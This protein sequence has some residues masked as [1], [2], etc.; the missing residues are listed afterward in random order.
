VGGLCLRQ[1]NKQTKT[2]MARQ[3]LIILPKLCNCNED[4]DKQW[5]V[6]YSCRD[7]RTGK[8][9][10]FRHYDGFTGT[11][12]HT[13][14][15]HAKELIEIF[16]ARLRSGW[17]PFTDDT[18]A[19][20]ND[21]ID[22]KTVAELYGSRQSGNNTVRLW[23]SRYLDSIIQGVRHSTYLTYKS[24]F[25]IFIL[26]LERE[27]VV[28][29]D[30]ATIDNKLIVMFFQYLLDERKLSH[31]SIGNY[32][33]L[34]IN[35]FSYFKKQKLIP[36]NPVFELP[37]CNR[38]NDQAP[39]PIQREDIEVFKKEIRKDPE[40]WLAVQFE[41][42]CGM[43]PGH[44]IRELKIKDIDYLAGTIYINRENAKAVETRIVTIPK[45]FLDVIRNTYQLQTF[46]RE[47]YIFGKGG[48]PG[49]VAIGKNKLSYRFRK[50]R[51]KLE[52]PVEYKFYSW[53]HTG[54]IEA[55][56]ANIPHKDISNH[57]GHSNM[58]TTD[59]Y[60]RNKKAKV[61]KAIRDNYPTL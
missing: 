47:Y 17:T 8:M 29:N 46:N 11:P 28:M 7:P 61:S 35:L 57:L 9:V 58:S 21:H 36:Y 14:I 38:I 49:P 37:V 20:Y 22:Y 53:K 33:E 18:Q 52:M 48:H 54:A 24:K 15:E 23:T 10:R 42:Y 31:E 25:R 43:R 32:T 60:F 6:Y 51:I 56:E 19:V 44:E 55:D 40:L 41:F 2:A 4:P 12:V 5:F 34:L 1:T 13:R 3:K 39:R 59:I 50:I 27:H 45:Q 30:I 26:W 16:S